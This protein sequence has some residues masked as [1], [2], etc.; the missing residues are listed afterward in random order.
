MILYICFVRRVSPSKK[1]FS[2]IPV[3]TWRTH[4]ISKRSSH[5]FGLRQSHCSSSRM[6]WI[7]WN[8]DTLTLISFAVAH[9]IFMWYP[10]SLSYYYKNIDGP[11]AICAAVEKYI[12]AQNT[13]GNKLLQFYSFFLSST[14]LCNCHFRTSVSNTSDGGDTGECVVDNNPLTFQ[15]YFLFD[16]VFITMFISVAVFMD[17]I[18]KKLLFCEDLV[19]SPS[20]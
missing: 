6:S 19:L 3:Q 8:W 17:R 12:V 11:V 16:C 18:G 1:Y 7:S 5:W 15:I 13:N 2:I 9:G 10:Q 4:T 20:L 14:M